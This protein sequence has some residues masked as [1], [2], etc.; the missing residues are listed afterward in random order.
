[1]KKVRCFLAVIGLLVTLGG[2]S[3]Q[4]MGVG[5]LI[6]ATAHMQTSS[7]QASSVAYRPYGPCPGGGEDDC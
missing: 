5:S 3:L 7:V 1:M 2:F 6:N 4:G